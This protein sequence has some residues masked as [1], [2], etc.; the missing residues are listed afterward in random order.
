MAGE[1]VSLREHQEL[2]E[3]VVRVEG[4]VQG[5][6]G[7]VSSIAERVEMV[8]AAID[9]MRSA[10][11]GMSSEHRLMAER[12]AVMAT[13]TTTLTGRIDRLIERLGLDTGAYPAAGGPTRSATPL[14]PTPGEQQHP[15]VAV[16]G[17]DATKLVAL[18]LGG[19]IGPRAAEFVAHLFG[20]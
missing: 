8:D 2:R 19:A 13:A 4:R 12:V 5:I 17:H 11:A 16:L 7:A 15:I 10:M 6:E 20:G 14:T 3:R 1:L 9:D 18:L